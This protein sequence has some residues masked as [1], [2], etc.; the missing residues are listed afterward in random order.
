MP[1]DE[2]RVRIP[3]VTLLKVALAILLVAVV[4]KLWTVIL[5]IVIAVLIGVM[6]DPLVLWGED[7]GVRRAIGVIAMAFL[8]FGS[9]LLF[10]AFVAP[11]MGHQVTDL[12]RQLPRVAQRLASVFPPIAPLLAELRGQSQQMEALATRGL[13]AG[14]YLLEGI[15]AVVFVLVVALYLLIDGR[16]AYVWLVSFVPARNRRRVDRTGRE[17]SVVVRSYLRG[18]TISAT[19]CAAYVLTVLSALHVPLA[20][21]LAVL[22]FIFDFVPVVGTIV[23]MIPATLLA[24]LVSPAHAIMVAAAYLLYHAIEAYVLLPRIYGQQMRVSTLT[25]L[26][27]MTIGATLQGIIGAVLA[28]P[29]AAAYPIVERIWLREY[30]P[31]DTVPRHE[32]LEEKV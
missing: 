18:A 8:I 7:H 31:E 22:A 20:L 24:L 9:L 19:I 2:L 3:F 5:M 27:A 4:V 10:L 28:I 12:L 15:T 30:L 25:I 21:V 1:A 29:I 16:R 23:M 17:I 11:V 6:L 32:E 26:L 14:K 13:I